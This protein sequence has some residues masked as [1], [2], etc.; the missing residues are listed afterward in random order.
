[1]SVEFDLKG[2]EGLE[3]KLLLLQRT[4]GKGAAK[5]MR[6]AV[7]RGLAP[8]L[9]AA[10]ASVPVDTGA[11]SKELRINVKRPS[12][13]D[14][15]SPYVSRDDTIIGTVSVKS[16]NKSLAAEFGTEDTP[17]QPFLIPSLEDNAVQVLSITGKVLF[18]EI[19]KLAAKGVK[20]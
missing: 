20:K 15:R 17:A 14:R 10:K 8:V 9:S 3:K 16:D 1:M 2:F 13:R 4:V 6:V 7:R 11:L 18:T 5:P 12:G 19:D